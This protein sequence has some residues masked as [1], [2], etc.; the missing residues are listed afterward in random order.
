M[1][2]GYFPERI[3]ELV[4]AMEGQD[5][6]FFFNGDPMKARSVLQRHL[7]NISAYID[8]VYIHEDISSRRDTYSDAQAFRDDLEHANS[9]RTNAHNAAMDSL[10]VVNRIFDAYGLEPFI[11][12]EPSMNRSD[13]GERIAGYISTAFLGSTKELTRSET[14]VLAHELGI[15]HEQRGIDL[16]DFLSRAFAFR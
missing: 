14:A 15:E 16:E 12:V 5:F 6:Q 3:I 7:D 4:E 2:S 8:R 11:E 10:N 1:E 13:I 9:M